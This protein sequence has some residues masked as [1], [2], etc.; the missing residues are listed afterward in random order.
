VV[1]GWEESRG[2]SIILELDWKPSSEQG[3]KQ[4]PAVGRRSIDSPPG[5]AVCAVGAGTLGLRFGC[6]HL[7]RVSGVYVWNMQ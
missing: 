5:R 7:F 1:G 3:G 6:L 2:V 4:C